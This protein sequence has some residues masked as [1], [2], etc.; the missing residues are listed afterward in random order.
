MLTLTIASCGKKTEDKKLKSFSES[1]RPSVEEVYFN[2]LKAL[3]KSVYENDIALLKKVLERNPNLDLDRIGD[4]GETLLTAA[5][6]KNHFEIRDYLIER[7]ASLDKANINKETPLIVAATHNRMES[8]MLLLRSHV[9]INR[10]NNQGNTALHIALENKNEDLA[11]LLI[12][13]GANIEITDKNDQNAY[14]LAQKHENHRV[15][16]LI[17]VI[18]HGLYGALEL[19]DFKR[20]LIEGSEEDLR[21]VLEKHPKL[22]T[23]YESLNPLVLAQEQK[24]EMTSWEMI[25]I[26]LSKNANINGPKN[27]ELTPLIKAIQLQ[28]TLVASYLIDQNADVNILDSEGKSA[29]IYAIE[30]NNNELV[31]QLMQYGAKRNYSITLKNG[32]SQS[33]SACSLAKKL[34]QDHMRNSLRCTFRDWFF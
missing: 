12:R 4:D 13:E 23:D 33:F 21:L 17:K 19:T 22:A 5:I 26:L 31:K 16:E 1:Y 15:L 29:L 3:K 24:N 14:K 20:V 2:A 8:A 7:G 32:K 9:E 11:L 25:K 27:A 18:L 30:L 10:K 28:H 34:M 6:Q